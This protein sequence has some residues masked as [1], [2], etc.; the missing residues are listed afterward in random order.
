[1]EK[2][3]SKGDRL[4]G[5]YDDPACGCDDKINKSDNGQSDSQ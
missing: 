5:N 1:M 3:N 2:N 4:F